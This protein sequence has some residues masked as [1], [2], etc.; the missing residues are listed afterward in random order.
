[1]NPLFVSSFCAAIS[2]LV[3]SFSTAGEM[4]KAGMQVIDVEDNRTVVHLE[5]GDVLQVL[6]PNGSGNFAHDLQ[7]DARRT[8]LKFTRS[9]AVSFRNDEGQIAVGGGQIA[10]FFDA[11]RPGDGELTIDVKRMFDRGEK[12][13]K[14]RI[15]VSAQPGGIGAARD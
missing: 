4:P 12:P 2:L 3:C 8:P 15:V 9:L 1:M 14:L 7:I 5:T 11:T 10:L 13:I 6:I